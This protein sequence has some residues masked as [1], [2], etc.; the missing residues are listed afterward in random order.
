VARLLEIVSP[1]RVKFLLLEEV[2]RDPGAAYHSVLQFLG[3]NDDHRRNFKVYNQAKTRRWRGLL[4]VAWAASN[5]RR[6]LGIERGL[7]L[8]TRIDAINRIERPRPPIDDDMRRILRNY[9]VADVVLLQN[10]IGRDLSH[11]LS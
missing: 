9:F 8:W 10:L 6:A 4:A 1:Q 3:V 5:V 2:A 11:W 7:G